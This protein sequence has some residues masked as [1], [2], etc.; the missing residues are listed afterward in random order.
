MKPME[1]YRTC[2]NKEIQDPLE[3]ITE[4]EHYTHHQLFELN[5]S[6]NGPGRKIAEFS[7]NSIG[8]PMKKTEGY[9]YC[10]Y[11]ICKND[12][13]VLEENGLDILTIDAQFDNYDYVAFIKPDE[14]IRRFEK[15]FQ[16][17]GVNVQ[18]D[19]VEY[20]DYYAHTGSLNQ[21]NKHIIHRQQKEYRF[22][23]PI[24]GQEDI[25]FSIGSL[26]DICKIGLIK[27]NQHIRFA[28]KK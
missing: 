14:F 21:F 11:A 7:G 27:S 4:I 20:L 25:C 8:Y 18:H 6:R 10:L 9:L 2:D 22:F 3:G 1:Y 13:R 23:F 16:G 24:Y 17:S 26:E 19:L 5:T 28:K 15:A 12:F